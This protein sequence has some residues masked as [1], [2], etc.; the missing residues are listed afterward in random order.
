MLSVGILGVIVMYSGFLYL[1]FSGR[2]TAALPWFFLIS[3]WLCIYFGLSQ[4]Q[5]VATLY[6]LKNK[7]SFSRK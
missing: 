4:T 1:F 3:P 6:W 2:S 7:F 5:Q